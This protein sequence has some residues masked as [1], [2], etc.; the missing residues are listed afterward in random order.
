M[1]ETSADAAELAHGALDVADTPAAA[2][3]DHHA[4]LLGQPERAPGLQRTAGLQELGGDQR[5]HQTRGALARDPLDGGHRLAV[6]D[7]VHVDPGLRPEEEARQVGDRGDGGTAHRA[8]AAQPREH[9]GDGGVGGDDHV[10]VVLGDAARQRAGAE[11]AQLPARQPAHGGHV[12][13]QPVDQRVAPGQEAQ[14]HAVAVLD[15]LAQHAPHRGKAVDHRDLGGLGGVFDL[16]GQR[17]GSRGVPLAD[18]GREDQD[19]AG[20]AVVGCLFLMS[21]IASAPSS[22]RRGWRSRPKADE[23]GPSFFSR[24]RSK[25]Y[26]QK[27]ST[28]GL[29]GGGAQEKHNLNLRREGHTSS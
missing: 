6:H 24:T 1:L 17:A 19:T 8:G 7:E 15:D 20:P 18:V 14:L 23:P 5:R 26:R 9:H 29:A 3:D 4:A 28:R 25:A 27:R 10:G 12:L 21:H 11:Q 2:R 13:E 22:R 16:L